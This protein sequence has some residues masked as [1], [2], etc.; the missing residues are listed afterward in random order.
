MVSLSQSP[1]GHAYWAV[2]FLLQES[3]I[4][5]PRQTTPLNPPEWTPT[6]SSVINSKR[7]ACASL[8]KHSDIQATGLVA[9]H[10]DVHVGFQV[11]R[12]GTEDG[13]NPGTSHYHTGST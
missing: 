8:F 11:V 3:I 12:L 5:A 10:P 2:S 7:E 6:Q 1:A 9:L 13:L 4:L